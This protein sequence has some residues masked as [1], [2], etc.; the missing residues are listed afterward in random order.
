MNRALIA[1]AAAFVVVVAA[2]GQYLRPLPAVA[3]RTITPARVTGSAP[4]LPC[5]A[6]GVSAAAVLGIGY[7]GQ[8]GPATG[9]QRMYSTAKLMTALLVLRDH[10][11]ARGD[12][13]PELTVSQADADSTSQRAAAGESVV[14]VAAGEQ[15]SELQLLEGLL[16]PSANNF[17]D[18]LAVWDAGS[19]E[20]FV[21]KMNA[22]AA[23]V[24]GSKGGTRFADTSGVSDQTTSVPFELLSLAQAAMANPVLSDIVGMATA[25]LPVAGTVYN[26]NSPLGHR[27]VVGIKTGSDPHGQAVFAGLTLRQVAGQA[28]AVYTVVMGAPDLATAFAETAGLVD[29]VAGGLEIWRLPF[30]REVAEY[31]APWGAA[32]AVRPVANLSLVVWPGSRIT[33]KY[34]L[35]PIPAGAPAGTRVGLLTVFYG[36]RAYA[37]ELE[38]A[39]TLNQ[40]GRRWRLTRGG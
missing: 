4:S 35:R 34:E 18:M 20:A 17:A 29:A 16:I 19:I 32:A 15:L 33:F 25:D 22:Q 10:P 3:A 28:V 37:V 30:T 12:G 36:E 6:T 38:T 21:A 11:L 8:C 1:A 5:P 26:V 23:A 31:D 27:G 9:P 39:G 7:F 13:G 2:A 14:R 24:F 40:P